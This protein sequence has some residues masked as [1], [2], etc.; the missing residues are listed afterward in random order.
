MLEGVFEPMVKFFR[1][2][3]SPAIF[4]EMMNNLLRDVIKKEEVAVF[5]NDVMIVTETEEG[6]DEIEEEVLRMM[7]ENDLF[8]KP[9]KYVWKVREV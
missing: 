2:T 3:N 6:H 5:I 1:L 4:Q 7:E 8:V 9:E